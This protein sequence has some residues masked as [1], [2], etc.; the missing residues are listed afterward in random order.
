MTRLFIEEKEIDLTDSVS[1]ALT[2]QFEDITKPTTIKD[3][4]SKTVSIPFTANNNRIF[5]DIYNPSRAIVNAPSDTESFTGLYFDPYRKLNFR[6]E[7]NN[8]I[9]MQGFAKMNS[10]EEKDGKG[11]YNITLFGELSKVFSDMSKITFNTASTETDFII[12]GSQ[13]FNE[14]LN[15]EL[16]YTSWT[17]SGQTTSTLKKKTDTG[18]KFTDIVGFAPN[19]TFSDNFNYSTVQT[20]TLNSREL[21][22]ILGTGFTEDAHVEPKTAIPNGLLP[23]EFGE[24]RSCNQ[25]SY[26]Y[27]NKLFKIFQEKAESTTGYEFELDNSWFNTSNPYWYRTVYMLNT[28]SSL[29]S[30]VYDNIYSNDSFDNTE[31]TKAYHTSDDPYFEKKSSTQWKFN[32]VNEQL[33]TINNYHQVFNLN[34]EYLTKA[35]CVVRG[36]I[37][38]NWNHT[39]NGTLTMLRDNWHIVVRCYLTNG[40]VRTLIGTF[41]YIGGEST[42]PVTSYGRPIVTKRTEFI[43]ISSQ[44]TN[45]SILMTINPTTFTLPPSKY[46]GQW[47]FYYETEVYNQVPGSNTVPFTTNIGQELSCNYVQVSVQPMQ[48]YFTVDNLVGKSYSRIN[49]ND[50]WNNEYSLFEE[51]MKYC[52]TYHLVVSCDINEKKIRFQ[53]LNN[54]FND[55]K[56][57]DWTDKI[58]RGRDY[59]IVP[60]SFENKYVI[61]NYEDNKTELSKQYLEKYG[62]NYGSY[63]L[64]TNYN[65]NTEKKELFKNIKSPITCTYSNYSWTTMHDYHKVMYTF[66][67]DIMICNSDKDKKQVDIF[68]TIFFFSGLVNFCTESVLELRPVYISDD[69]EYQQNNSIYMY[70]DT[71]SAYLKNNYEVLVSTYPKLDIVYSNNLCTFNTPMENF[72]YLNNYSQKSTIY[73][74]YWKNFIDERYN[75]QNKII[76]CYVNLKPEDYSN[77]EF[78]KFVL[79]DNQLY[80]VNKI[81][82]YDVTNNN[83]TKVDLITVNDISGY[84]GGL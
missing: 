83:S 54:Y 56:V 58:D 63:R 73:S 84:T 9:L 57:L 27:F 36:Q 14:I 66:P 72:T 35:N 47:W 67:A 55:Y 3:D 61:F 74:Q 23:R 7:W 18:Y 4:W 13:Y 71:S 17:T 50:L 65:F 10:V 19:N 29:K 28:L 43:D 53:T 76:T 59:K 49:L 31:S 21:T 78:K 62:L 79:I 40:P 46:D 6:L 37:T 24:F 20:D 38:L 26:I 80:I 44:G 51:I 22:D 11:V 32:N 12:D 68:G 5:G 25:L 77:F 34:G 16:V 70:L 60:I 39:G 41:D 69:T 42:P 2:K 75:V 81:Y 45:D 8:N 52:C 15:K 33:P 1:F 48:F 30:K 64:I 82:D